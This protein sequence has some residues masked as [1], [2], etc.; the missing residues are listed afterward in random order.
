MLLHKLHRRL[1]KL[2][3]SGLLLVPVSKIYGIA[4]GVGIAVYSSRIAFSKSMKYCR[5]WRPR[6]VLSII[7]MCLAHSIETA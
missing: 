4:R 5:I 7:A 3:Q 6:S 1:Q 2:K